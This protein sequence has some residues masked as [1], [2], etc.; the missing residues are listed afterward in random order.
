MAD[1]QAIALG[2]KNRLATISGLRAFDRIPDTLPVPAAFV[3]GP[4][5][6]KR[7]TMGSTKRDWRLPIRIL[8]ARV[9]DRVGQ[10][11]LNDYLV[12]GTT[13]IDDAIDGDRTLGGIA[14]F[15]V[16]QDSCTGYGVYDA[17]GIKYWGY[18]V[19]VRVV[20]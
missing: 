5:S 15:A 12:I 3:G 16:V 19:P 17:N 14:D 10:A 20:A 8:V 7:L 18:E 6:A 2:L 13:S 11:K 9:D 1:F 4:T